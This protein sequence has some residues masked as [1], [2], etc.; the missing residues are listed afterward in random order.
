MKRKHT[1]AILYA[2]LYTDDA[3]GRTTL[4]GVFPTIETVQVAQAEHTAEGDNRSL[5]DYE[6]TEGTMGSRYWY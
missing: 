2:L 4:L 5:Y 6:I 1:E 3:S